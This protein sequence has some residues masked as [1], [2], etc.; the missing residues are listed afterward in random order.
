[1]ALEDTAAVA[2]RL[3]K[4]FGF[5]EHGAD[6]VAAK[7]GRLSPDLATQAEAWW[8][9]GAAISM[10]AHGHTVESLRRDH[11][12]GDV[13][14]ILTLDWIMREPEKALRQLARG[15]DSIR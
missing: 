8:T 5:P 15:H 7:L 10:E 13:A 9:R 6:I 3:V 1:M 12:L 14:A 4:E 2:S 11:G